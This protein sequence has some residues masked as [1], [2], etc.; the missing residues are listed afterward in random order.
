MNLTMLLKRLIAVTVVLIFVAGGGSL[1]WVAYLR[2]TGNVHEIEPGVFRSAQLD[3]NEL[4]S[5]AREHGISTVINLRGEGRGEP[6]FDAEAAALAANGAA[7]V[8]LP[9]LAN[10]IPDR[11]LMARL[12][13]TLKTTPPPFLIHCRA[14]ADRSG[15][16]SALYE[17]LVNKRRAPEASAQLSFAF[18]HFPWLGSDTGAM[19]TAFWQVVGDQAAGR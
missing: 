14:G 3:A 18:G 8:N 15:L 5:L 10:Q 4:V 1:G 6:W 7:M 11:D 12:I 16:A 2:E 19:D 17:Y 9:L 13:D